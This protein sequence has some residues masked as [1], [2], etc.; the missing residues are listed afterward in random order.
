MNKDLHDIDN[1]FRSSLE[2]YEEAPSPS[3]REKLEASLDKTDAESYKK[4]FYVWKRAAILLFFLLIG[5][6]LYEAGIIRI[7]PGNS[8]KNYAGKKTRYPAS[9]DQKN[10]KNDIPPGDKKIDE[11]VSLSAKR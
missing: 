3:V 1:L 7:S 11:P 9:D 5:I 8:E 10:E 6:V 4:D 2:S